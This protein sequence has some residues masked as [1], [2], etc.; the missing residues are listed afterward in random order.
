MEELIS[1]VEDRAVASYLREV[2]ACYGAGAYRACIVLTHIALFDGLRL[3]IM[4]LAPVNK[5]AKAVSEEIEQIAEAQKPF[6]TQLI[7]KLKAAK[8]V[9]EL[10][11]TLLEKLNDHR[12]KAA[13][14]SGHVVTAEE[15]R[16]VFSE[17]I[18]KFLNRPIRQTSYI[19]DKILSRI[20]DKNFF[21]SRTVTDMKALVAV[22]LL[23]LDASAMPFLLK[24][25]IEARE[26]S[27]K[28][29]TISSEGF[30]LALAS[31]RDEKVRGLLVKYLVDPRSSHL[32]NAEF[33]SVLVAA[34]PQILSGLGAAAEQRMKS[35]MLT[36]AKAV[37]TTGPFAHL[38]SPLQV[39][40][41]AVGLLGESFMVEKYPEFVYWVIDQVP[42]SPD[43]VSCLKDSSK[44]RE[45][46]FGKYVA[47]ASSAD[48][49]TANNFAGVLASLDEPLDTWITEEQAF[50]LVASVA[51]AAQYGAYTPSAL[52]RDA[53]ASIPRLRAKA[54]SLAIQN[55]VTA[56]ELC[57]RLGL[58]EG[59]TEF[60]NQHLQ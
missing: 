59:G 24:R 3:K 21:P 55:I 7:H 41:S 47:R 22:E 48:F 35:L 45:R 49:S 54:K 38:R 30:L 39:L 19:V 10:E 50:E 6:E 8:I 60:L 43:F 27:D 23:N 58:L 33:F 11:A 31:K 28:D 5:I 4:A 46:L 40:G 9:T 17:A 53:F 25:L 51:R 14:P 13:H 2:L 44:L 34:D 36:N 42:Y 12:N 20:S 1:G 56:D 37:G 15:A 52:V 18:T 32:E 57:D 29:A 26:G 16:Y